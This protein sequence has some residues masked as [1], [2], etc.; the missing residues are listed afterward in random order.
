MSN[1]A[2][3]A[4]DRFQKT[5]EMLSK[6]KVTKNNAFEN[7]L[8][9]KNCSL[10]DNARQGASEEKWRYYS[11][12]VDACGR[13]YGFCVDH[14]YEE[15]FKI[16]GGVIRSNENDANI[17]NRS[18]SYQKKNPVHGVLTIEHNESAMT[19]KDLDKLEKTDPFL[20]SMRKK[21]DSNKFCTML[22]NTILINSNLDL[23]YSPDDKILSQE[24]N[25]E[26]L[27]LKQE[28]VP[29]LNELDL[30][31][32]EI[33]PYLE[34]SLI[35]SSSITP[36]CTE[37]FN[38]FDQPLAQAPYEDSH[39]SDSETN[40]KLNQEHPEPDMKVTMEEI[41]ENNQKLDFIEPNTLV[42]S[43]N[44][45]TNVTKS[46]KK[47]PRKDPLKDANYKH[48]TKILKIELD[49]EGENQLPKHQKQDYIHPPHSNNTEIGYKTSR[50][51]ELFTRALSPSNS[52]SF[53]TQDTTD[54]MLPEYP[55]PSTP[56]H[57]QEKKLDFDL[58]YLKE[59]LSK[60]LKQ[61]KKDFFSLIDSLSSTID[62]NS[63]SNISFHS[64]FVTLLHL[65]N[66]QSLS[67]EKQSEFNFLIK[68]S[69]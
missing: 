56:D 57:Q 50:L 43:K 54:L 49:S 10:I 13:V 4:F 23:V 36:N 9:D 64:C 24:E 58:H 45:E 46:P 40:Q 47:R 2:T 53:P 11:T 32:M 19:I 34:K 63:S 22:L 12:I 61:P 65:A 5:V 18:Q 52:S 38:C 20:E 66:E 7:R 33:C 62:P 69:H 1:N 39:Y 67:L 48:P 21:F 16:L 14:V 6:N 30:F 37:I 68:K 42:L 35:K 17:E 8:L 3:D 26:E 25:N 27:Q 51:N 15:T 28:T 31:T 59:S 44:L 29:S 55:N 41:L 60:A